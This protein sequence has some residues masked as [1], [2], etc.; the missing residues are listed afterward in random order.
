[1]GILSW[2]IRPPAGHDDSGTDGRNRE[3]PVLTVLRAHNGGGTSDGTYEDFLDRPSVRKAMRDDAELRG[4]IPMDRSATLELADRFQDVYGERLRSICGYRDDA[5]PFAVNQMMFETPWSKYDGT[6][7]WV[8]TDG[9]TYRTY[10]ERGRIDPVE[11]VDDEDAVAYDLVRAIVNERAYRIMSAKP[12]EPWTHREWLIRLCALQEA[13]MA[14]FG[15]AW[16]DRLA[17]E[18]ER[19]LRHY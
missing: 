19:L 2:L 10:Q 4:Y 14:C 15:D 12:H 8:G 6:Y 17:E 18:D 13:L 7:L 1:M 11:S 3:S 5:D 9:N 16:R